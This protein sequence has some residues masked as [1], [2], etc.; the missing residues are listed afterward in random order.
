[1]EFNNKFKE[2]KDVLFNVQDEEYENLALKCF[3]IAKR[4]WKERRFTNDGDFEQRKRV[5]EEKSNPLMTFIK[6]NY[7]KDIQKEVLFSEFYDDLSEFLE[8]RGFRT[9]SA[10]AV[11]QQVKNEGFDI[12]TLQKGGVN[13]RFI[14]GLNHINHIN[15][16]CDQKSRNDEK[17]EIV[18]IVNMVNNPFQ[19]Y[20]KSLSEKAL[21]E[22]SQRLAENNLENDEN[23][24]KK[25]FYDKLS[26]FGF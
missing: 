10:K 4:L 12:K 3:N 11:S 13:G 19:S 25:A 26:S 15:H 23:Q 9:L 1:M 17:L 7:E 2:E 8:S 18:N 14:I 21:A 6:E 16:L 24:Q 22:N 5:Y 20:E